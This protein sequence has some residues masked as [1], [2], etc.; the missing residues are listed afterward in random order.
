MKSTF[1]VQDRFHAS[2][3]ARTLIQG[4]DR[5]NGKDRFCHI[6]ASPRT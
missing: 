2:L 5:N 1:R 4:F 6:K 3:Y